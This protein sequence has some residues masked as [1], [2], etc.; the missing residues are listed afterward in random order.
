MNLASPFLL[1]LHMTTR[2]MPHPRRVAPFS[3]SLL[4]VVLLAMALRL[5]RLG[6][7]SIWYDESVS[8]YLAR[9]SLPDLIAHTAG[10]IHPPLYYVLLHGWLR[11]AGGSAFAAAFLSLFCG[12]L[13]VPAVYLT[14][15]RLLGSRTALLAAFL[16][17]LSPFNL[18]YAQ[19][20][21]MYTVGALLGI[22]SFYCLLRALFPPSR[23]WRPWLGYVLCAALGLYTLYYFAFL[24]LFESLAVVALW[25]RSRRAPDGEWAVSTRSLLRWL[26]AQA[27]VL[28]LYLPWLGVAVRQASQPPVPP[29]RG[30]SG[31]AAVVE[32]SWAALSLGQSVEVQAV[33]LLL[34]LFAVLYGAALLLGEHH[35]AP[36]LLAAYSAVPLLLIYLASLYTPL[37][38]VRYVFLFAP[39]FYIVL[40]RGLSLAGRL[41]PAAAALALAVIVLAG[42]RS[43][44]SYFFDTAY[45][46]DDH[47]AA[48]ALISRRAGAGDAL[49]INAGYAYPAFLYYYDGDIAWRGR[50][51]DYAKQPPAGGTGITILQTGS[52][53]GAASLGWGNPSSDFY[54]TTEA[55]TAAALAEVMR[56]HSRI[57]VYRIYDTVTD[58][59]SFVR[60]YLDEHMPLLDE[61]TFTGASSLRIQLYLAPQTPPSAPPLA[62]LGDSMTLRSF[63]L[64]GPSAAP[65]K[66]AYLTTTWQ[67]SQKTN[68]NLRSFV[69]MV[70]GR[71]QEW[72]HWDDVAG[73]RLYPS[74]VW[75]D[76]A[77]MPQVWRLDIPPGTPPGRYSLE[78]G[79]YDA[80]SGARLPVQG[81]APGAT[82]NSLRLAD[83]TVERSA[84]PATLSALPVQ[85][86]LDVNLAGEVSLVGY[87][88]S[89][90]LARPGDAV[91]VTAYWRAMAK[92][93]G[94]RTLFVQLL[95]GQGRLAANWE[96][97]AAGGV[98]PVAAWDA[99]ALVRDRYRVTVPANTPDGELRLVLGMYRTNDRT[100]LAVQG[101]LPWARRDTVD[102]GTIRVA[103][104]ERNFVV[105]SMQRRLAA[106]F[107]NQAVLLGYDLAPEPASA[108][109]GAPLVVSAGDTLRL[110]LYWQDSEPMDTSYSVFVQLLGAGDRIGAQQD[111][112]PGNGNLPTTSWVAGEVISDRHDLNLRTAAPGEYR[113]VV[114]LYERE[115]GRRLPI[116]VN[117]AAQ[118]GDM[119]ALQTV[120]VR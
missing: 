100:R 95:D 78:A 58:P 88:V 119:L 48:A 39:A 28:V 50:L 116:V 55:E 47:R 71:G 90:R 61:A 21:R 92:P 86:H 89:S 42:L 102:L 35:T 97:A 32:E 49:L 112:L 44:Q 65:G 110:T 74:S 76:G 56:R 22:L 73:G 20:I 105:P 113:L 66:P 38:H 77:V 64:S 36:L 82:G 43:S 62:R 67:L 33:A 114:G 54:A 5:F 13:L 31:L 108:G 68:T 14:A 46:A 60:R 120:T 118:A 27:A 75:P 79:L 101:G 87:S 23:A 12:V 53:G 115:S 11:L 98:Y 69:S 117:G 59:Q 52:I 15:R 3:A 10:D 41:A 45:A 106:R 96:G 19:E 70:D 18:W 57:W 93:R 24:L 109:A 111:G 2:L 94:E 104:R 37:F 25:L 1:F 72:A 63:A 84:A 7:G 16:V 99:G 4:W 80:A 17:A 30:F 83:L 85:N 8:I 29:W 26:A 107:G 103:G 6:A 51:T 40:A 9:L 91:E 81:G 34:L